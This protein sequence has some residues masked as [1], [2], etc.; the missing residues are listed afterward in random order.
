MNFPLRTSDAGGAA[1]ASLFHALRLIF[2]LRSF[3]EQLGQWRERASVKRSMKAVCL[4]AT[5]FGLASCG[6]QSPPEPPRVEIPMQVTDLR[7]V[8]IGRTVNITFTMPTLATDGELLNKPVEIEVF[9]SIS[10]SGQPPAP[11][12]TKNTPWLSLTSHELPRYVHNGK[13][14]YSLQ[15]PPDEFRRRIGSTL[16]FAVI[17]LT[18]GFRGRA[19]KS[20][21]SN[22]A[23][24]AFLDVTQP[25][26]DLQVKATQ[27]ALLLTWAKPSE[28]L[29][30]AAPTHLSGYR[31][32]QS[33]TGKPGSFE[34]LATTDSTQYEDANFQFGRPYYFRVSAVTEI[35]GSQAESEPSAPVGITPRDIFPPPVPT[36]LQAFNAAG[37]VDLLWDASAA[38]DLAGYNVYRSTDGG[39]FERVNKQLAPTPIFHDATVAPGH[40]YQ[41]SVTAVDLSGN[42]SERS[43]PASVTTPA[44]GQ[45]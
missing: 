9:R 42:E 45:P 14:E 39:P 3:H 12:D 22:R 38:P 16:S 25:V 7:A 13:F 23:E 37:A 8:Q 1:A 6:V 4:V 17:A 10:P 40:H 19:R 11:P 35:D 2:H 44:P 36:G 33:A 15:L 32:Y 41:Y 29:A 30:G 24:A 34:L 28:T 27:T 20:P 31:I 5:V 18:R 21:P 43:Q 26:T